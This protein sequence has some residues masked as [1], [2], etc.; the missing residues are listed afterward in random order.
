MNDSNPLSS[1]GSSSE[2]ALLSEPVRQFS[3]AR[4]R[5]TYERLVQAAGALFDERGFD[6]TQT[7]DIAGAAAVS[8][9][10]FYRYF[11]DKRAVYLE[12]MRRD[13]SEAYHAVLDGLTPARFAGKGRRGATEGAIAI[14][15]EQV[16]RAPQRHRVFME[17]SLRDPQIAELRDVFESASCARL[18][19]LLTAVCS[20]EQVPDPEATAYIVYTAVV[21]CAH[22]I[23]G[24]R[25]PCK[26]DRDRS[27]AALTDLVL[28]TLFGSAE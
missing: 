18:T 4:A 21:E 10:T 25:G 16:T 20:R 13:I 5:R 17:M 2:H 27:M 1:A 26:L 3:Q 12:V 11:T 24:L 8:V 6:A 15:L 19:T 23:A 9:G 28:R 22:R 14:L 7:P